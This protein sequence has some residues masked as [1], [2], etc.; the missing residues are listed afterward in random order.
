M[1]GRLGGFLDDA[2]PMLS[3][4]QQVP[5]TFLP[6]YGFA[7]FLQAYPFEVGIRHFC[8]VDILIDAMSCPWGLERRD[9]HPPTL[10]RMNENHY[11]L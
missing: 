7:R 5:Q 4:S 10:V 6:A 2:T 11:G 1:A 8:N 9:G 3:D